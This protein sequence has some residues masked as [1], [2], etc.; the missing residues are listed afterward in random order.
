MSHGRSDYGSMRDNWRRRRESDGWWKASEGKHRLRIL[1]PPANQDQAKFKQKGFFVE[2]GVH[3]DIGE[4]GTDPITCAKATL[5][6]SCPVCEFVK[7]LW[8]SGQ[9]DSHKL[10]RRI[11]VK[12]RAV[13]N[14]ILISEP[15]KVWI[16]S[17]PKTTREQIEDICFAN[18]ENPAMIDDPDSGN[19]LILTVTTRVT[20]EGNFPV[21]SITPELRP[22]ALPDK[23]VL[24]RLV[25]LAEVVG[26]RVKSY[27]EIRS[28]LHGSAAATEVTA[29]KAAWHSTQLAPWP[30]P[31][32]KEDLIKASA[33]NEVI[34]E[35]PAPP[36]APSPEGSRSSSADVIARA[37]AALARRQQTGG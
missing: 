27:D 32:S 9:E 1:P 23:G 37:K 8:R 29:P 34:E 4:E 10:A 25:N 2:Y 3:Y 7:G 33:E 22:S 14:I 31:T 36:S 19:N 26:S 18:D 15:S 13:S 20:Q 30:E 28:V 35:M 11:G 21:Q 6:R 17:Y 16:W 24:S 12:Q 5:N